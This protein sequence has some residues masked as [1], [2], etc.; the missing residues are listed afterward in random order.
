MSGYKESMKLKIKNQGINVIDI[1]Q[2]E[3]ENKT[4]NL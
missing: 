2:S 4:I 1:S 3:Q